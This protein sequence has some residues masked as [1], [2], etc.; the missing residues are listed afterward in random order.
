[1]RFPAKTTGTGNTLT[2]YRVAI[3]KAGPAPRTA[4]QSSEMLVSSVQTSDNVELTWIAVFTDSHDAAVCQHHLDLYDI[5]HAQAI[6]AA[7]EAKAGKE[8]DRRPDGVRGP[9]Q[10]TVSA[11]HLHRVSDQRT[12]GYGKVLSFP[13]SYPSRH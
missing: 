13:A 10:T 7:Y 6:H 4:H 11:L 5:V 9:I 12:K 8:Q 1:M 3:P 2:L